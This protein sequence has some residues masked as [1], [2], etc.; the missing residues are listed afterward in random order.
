MNLKKNH[1]IW[2]S[3]LT[4][5]EQGIV[6]RTFPLG[7]SCVYSYAKKILGKQFNFKLFK[8]PSRLNEELRQKSPT[9]LCF[10]NYKWNFNLSYKFAYLAKLRNPNLITVWGGP[11]FPIDINEKIKFLQKWP[12]IDFSIELEGEL[13]FV[14]LIKKLSER[15]NLKKKVWEC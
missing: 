12:A 14:D 13:G 1:D 10:S 11:N 2:I 5:T 8:F 7:A 9:M 3:D 6:S 4:H 15:Y